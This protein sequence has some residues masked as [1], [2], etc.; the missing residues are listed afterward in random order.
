M[1]IISALTI[2]IQQCTGIYSWSYK[3]RERKNIINIEKEEVKLFLFIE[4][5]IIYIEKS[6]DFVKQL[7]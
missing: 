4:Y 5:I 2:S 3:A 6:K 7:L 1:Q